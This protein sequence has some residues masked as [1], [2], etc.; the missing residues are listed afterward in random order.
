MSNYSSNCL[1]NPSLS[2]AA[3]KSVRA[4][5]AAANTTF[6]WP[7]NGTRICVPQQRMPFYWPP[8]YYHSDSRVSVEYDLSSAW[9][10][11]QNN[12]GNGTE[13][14]SQYMFT[15]KALPIPG[16]MNEKSMKM[17]M[18]ERRFT[19]EE[20]V[21]PY[22][23][24]VH[25]GP[26]V[27]LVKTAEFTSTIQSARATATARPNYSSSSDD[28][29]RPKLA[30]GAVAGIVIGALVALFLLI[31]CCSCCGCCGA[32]KK[33]GRTETSLTAEEQA[34]I[35]S[36]GTELLEQGKVVHPH[37]QSIPRPVV[38]HGRVMGVDDARGEEG[39]VPGYAEEAPPKYTP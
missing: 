10:F 5:Q 1:S 16:T 25:E 2:I 12:T 34:R 37:G 38:V 33:N 17:Y 29:D 30:G 28:N 36:Q 15:S 23:L 26:A 14:F 11:L 39:R 21:D 20:G 9:L 24:E 8:A 27:I 18:R 7:P 13:Y 22:N 31:C 6:C 35:V 19:K 3:L 4:C 32:K